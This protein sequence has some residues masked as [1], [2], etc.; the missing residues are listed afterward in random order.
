MFLS[1]LTVG[2]YYHSDSIL[3]RLDPRT[4]LLASLI[5]MTCLLLSR[6]LAEVLLHGSICLV[7]FYFSKIPIK[8][9]LRNLK[10]F[11]WLFLITFCIHIFT[12]PGVSLFKM[13]LLGFQ[14]TEQGLTNGLTY[15]VRLSLFIICSALLTLTTAPIELTDSLEKLLSPL[16]RFKMPVHE[17]VLMIT[18]SLRFLPLLI[19]EAERIKN[20]QLS[21]GLS[22]DGNLLQRIKNIVP[23]ILPLFVSVIRRANDLATA[24]EA[25]HYIGGEGRTSF[26]Q[27]RLRPADYRL[28]FFSMVYLMGVIFL[29]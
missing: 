15:S 29:V 27:L 12:T 10:P 13:P 16:R 25:R 8:L 2:Q 19:R 4:K 1:D 6:S 14:I 17:F 26:R 5:F 7:G 28:M 20:A 9:V 24:M 21:R 22:L 23:M 18:L 11:L 3:H